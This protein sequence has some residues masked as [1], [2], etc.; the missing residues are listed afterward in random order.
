MPVE[1][2]GNGYQATVHYKGARYRRQFPTK[3][4]A[5]AWELQAKASL[6]NGQTPDLPVTNLSGSPTTLSGLQEL[7]RKLHWQGTA[8]EKI[9]LINSTSCIKELGDISPSKVSTQTIDAMVF[10]WMDDGVADATINRRLSA[11][12]KMLRTA[13]DRGFLIILPKIDRRTERNGR[14]RFLT[15]QEESEVLSWFLFM[16]RKDMFDLVV[17]ALDT[18]M[19]QSELLRIEAR[20]IH[21]ELIHVWETKNKQPRSVPMTSRV[22]R[23]VSQR[24]ST[25]TLF[26][27]L[28]KDMVRQAW[29]GA[30]AHMGFSDDPQFVFHALRHTFV[31]RLVQRGVNLRTVA[32]IAGHKA[33]TT[34]MR[35]AHLAPKNLVDAIK[36]L[37]EP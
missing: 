1:Q 12:S 29:D 2:R 9:A 34:T 8:G 22:M 25:G 30:R 18:G 20:D 36:V 33:L 5:E 13:H 37:E 27:S 14:I 21:D 24:S 15:Q 6:I 28:T 17:M 3:I 16:D 35:Y 10:K 19:R 7:T 32:E 26:P 4:E 31:S 11:L 23:I